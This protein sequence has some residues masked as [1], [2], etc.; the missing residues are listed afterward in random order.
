MAV[1][2]RSESPCFVT[3][4]SSGVGSGVTGDAGRSTLRTSCV[5]P[6]VGVSAAFW[7]LVSTLA[8]RSDGPAGVGDATTE[9][10]ILEG[11]EAE[12]INLGSGVGAAVGSAT[13][14]VVAA[15]TGVIWN[16]TAVPFADTGATDWAIGA[17]CCGVVATKAPDLDAAD[18]KGSRGA[19][20]K[21]AAIVKATMNVAM[22]RFPSN[23]ATSHPTLNLRATS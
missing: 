3:P 6:T 5:V 11:N 1:T 13:S 12:D 20:A 2:A 16:P 7:L 22:I 10:R 9:G 19:Q 17:G 4:A 15:L 23:F 8:V 21:A 14:S 18:S